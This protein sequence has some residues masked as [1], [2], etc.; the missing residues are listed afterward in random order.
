MENS[1]DNIEDFLSDES[2]RSWVKDST[3]ELDAQWTSWLQNNP[4]SVELLKEA[5]EFIQLIK[6]DEY[7][8][9]LGSKQRILNKIQLE[10]K[11][12]KLKQLPLLNYWIRVAAVLIVAFG[13]GSLAFFV[14]SN[15]V[16]SAQNGSISSI[17]QKKNPFG[18]KSQ[19]L[20][21]DG[22]K[23]YLNS[24][25]SLEYPKTFENDS[26]VVRLIGEAFFEV[27][28]DN[29][30]PFKV[31]ADNFEVE[32]LGTEFNVNTSFS[33]NPTVALVDGRVR[34]K[35]I[36]SGADLDLIPGQMATYIISDELF[37]TSTFDVDYVTAWKE[38]NLVFQDAT[39]DE[40]VGRLHRWYG[41]GI[42]ISGKPSSDW[43]YTASFK[44]ESLEKVL[45]NMSTLR[46]FEYEIKNDSLIIS[47]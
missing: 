43:S 31:V 3:P 29:K 30:R 44:N 4:D 15:Q 45:F 7:Q 27:A 8:T 32:V 42:A 5:R 24:G 46:G 28:H 39:L 25:S 40:V 26:R 35:A 34:L 47:F 22:S 11:T 18:V 12:E 38:G 13:L 2:F 6:F 23:V 16:N 1:F 41:I 19:H 37:L 36:A 17:I 33:N 21:S 10:T 20:L 9:D 14:V